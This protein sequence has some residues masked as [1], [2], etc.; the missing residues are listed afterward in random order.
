MSQ[1]IL[2]SHLKVQNANAIAGFTWGFPAITHFLG[3][4]HNL[5]RKLKNIPELANISLSGC[6]VIAHEHHVHR[7]GTWDTEFTQNRNPP[8]LGSHI[9]TDTPP[10]IEEGK[11]NM[12]V[13]LL[14]GCFGTVGNRKDDLIAWLNKACLTQRLAG[15]TLLNNALTIEL[16]SDSSD[17]VRTIKR[18]L[19]PGFVLMDRASYLQ[20]HY[21]NLCKNNP[22]TELLDAWLDFAALKKVARPKSDL[23]SKHLLTLSNNLPDNL[24]L[25]VLHNAWQ[26]HLTL[27]YTHDAIPTVLIQYFAEIKQDKTSAS[28]LQQWSEYLGPNEKTNADWEH[29]PKPNSGYL[30][31]IMTGYKAISPVYPAGDVKSTRDTETP[32]CFVESVHSVGEWKSIHRIK[33]IEALNACLWHYHYEDNWYLCQQLPNAIPSSQVADSYEMIEDAETNFY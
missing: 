25:T 30:V 9:K 13:S 17:N 16:F 23:I 32:T 4:T 20:E 18:K 22:Q 5:E 31:P 14:I 28:L 24:Q 10:V 26:Q 11:M 15:G 2:I 33:D 27:P 8:Y 3:F 7:Y 1:Y 19:L 12:T 21:K 6:A 29:L